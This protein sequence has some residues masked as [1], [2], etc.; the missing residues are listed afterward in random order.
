MFPSA[1]RVAI[2]VLSF[3]LA[4]FAFILAVSGQAAFGQESLTAKS[5]E[6]VWFTTLEEIATYCAKGGHGEMFRYPS[7]VVG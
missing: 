4:T 7:Q 3:A 2:V 6:G 5:F 1:R